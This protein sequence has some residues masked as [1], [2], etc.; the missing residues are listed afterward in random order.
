MHSFVTSFAGLFDP[1]DED[2]PAIEAIEIPAIQR[3][4]A[5]GREDEAVQNIRRNF[6]DVLCDAVSGG[7]PVGLDFIY[8]EV[9]DGRLY[10]LDGQQR[11]TTLFL[12]HWYVASR[13]G[14]VAETPA[15][16]QFSYSTRPSAR[17]FCE[18]LA[19]V[20]LPEL[21]SSPA[22]WIKDQPWCLYVWRPDPTIRSMLVV[23]DA[24]HERLAEAD[25]DAAWHRLVVDDSPAISFDFLPIEDMGAADELYIKMNSRGKPL[26]DFE[27]FKARFERVLEGSPRSDEFAQKI[28]GPWADLLW[29]HHG[30]DNVVDN[31]FWNYISYVVELCEW[32]RGTA[33][34]RHASL[35]NRARQ[36]FDPTEPDSAEDLD[37]LFHAFDTWTGSDVD[38]FFE[39]HLAAVPATND[40]GEAKV[41]VFG[42]DAATNLFDSCLRE[43]GNERRFGSQRKLLLYAVLLHRKDHTAAFPNRL[44][45]VRNLLAASEDEVRPSAMGEIVE[46]VRRVVL[47]GDLDAVS[48]LNQAAL[49]DEIRKQS[50]LEAHPEA[51]PVV[52]RLEDHDLLRG[53][54]VALS[55][56]ADRLADRADVLERILSE[57][58]LMISFTGALLARGEYQRKIGPSLR[59]GPPQ[60]SKWWRQLLTGTDRENLAL[61][62]AALELVLD[63]LC[64]PGPADAE[65][66]EQIQNDWLQTQEA[67][68]RFE[69]RYYLVR[70]PVMRS[71]RS[72]VYR[73]PDQAMGYS[74]CMLQGVQ[75]NGYYRDPYLAAI[76]GE[77]ECA[78]SVVGADNDGPWF[79]GQATN[80]RWL[81]L[82]QSGV[83]LRVVPAGFEVMP[84]VLDEHRPGFD[85]VLLERD[86]IDES[87]DRV[88]LNIPQ[89]EC[90]E[91]LVDTVDRIQV[92]TALL[93]DLLASGC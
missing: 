82:K 22:E 31:E 80:E 27:N 90:G 66:L 19:K 83:R 4:Y 85:S 74:L 57:P 7:D 60:P 28:D 65:R 39:Q 70:Y 62:R 68:A 51:R 42:V 79:I 72:G 15:W 78:D 92:A 43:F 45:V 48:T 38:G 5:Q 49:A 12:L 67:D 26:T 17:L 47:E 20:T 33:P 18:R 8:G 75:L 14:R 84:P 36:A 81:E 55:L 93:G 23:I 73:S 56:D 88:L 2:V 34:D 13:T 9:E 30:G 32:R 24:I 21:D 50:F 29:P 10:P 86:D 87:G 52:H 53:S 37:L 40:Q 41:V 35:L 69:W 44:R 77:A 89:V 76:I 64:G 3:D 59:F 6:L 54:L 58:E 46:D 63:A 91:D 11:L 71:G 1:E 16:S 61:T 25:L